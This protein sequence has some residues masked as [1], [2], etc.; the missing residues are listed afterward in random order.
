MSRWLEMARAFKAEERA[1]KTERDL[2]KAGIDFRGVVV[3][4]RIRAQRHHTAS[5]VDEEGRNRND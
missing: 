3:L 2:T 5:E 1:A 4:D